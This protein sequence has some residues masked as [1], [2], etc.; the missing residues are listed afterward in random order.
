MRILYHPDGSIE[1]MTDGCY[2]L[3]RCSYDVA[4]GTRA[5]RIGSELERTIGRLSTDDAFRT[6]LFQKYAE[7]GVIVRG[8][9][10]V[11]FH[12]DDG[13]TWFDVPTYKLW[14][15]V[16][17]TIVSEPHPTDKR[18]RWLIMRVG[19][20]GVLTPISRQFYTYNE[21]MEHCDRIAITPMP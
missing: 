19:D 8:V 17:Y 4:N 21:A 6:K 16:K 11:T 3:E 9:S 14:R 15:H 10:G 5:V 18:C 2:T 13:F 1:R 20:D 7:H 12:T